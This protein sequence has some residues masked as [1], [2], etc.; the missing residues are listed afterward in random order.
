MANACPPALV[1][2]GDT[3]R[4]LGRG[5]HGGCVVWT[6][7]PVSSARSAR[8]DARGVSRPR[9][10]PAAASE[11]PLS[12]SEA[13]A[14]LFAQLYASSLKNESVSA[15][16]A[17]ERGSLL[18]FAYGHPWRWGEQR[19]EWAEQLKQRLGTPAEVLDGAHV[20]SLLARHPSAQGS[21]TGGRVLDAW[22]TG[23]GGG[24]SWLQTSDIPSPARRLYGA[25]GFAP[26]GHGPDAPDGTPG[27]V[28]YRNGDSR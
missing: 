22:L 4:I 25:R 7:D 26:I 27:L 9:A 3:S 6:R 13:V 19:D 24:P 18:G 21:G 2:L 17:Y 8:S 23:I 14:D 11:P 20:L 1:E 12:E 16:V 28:M 15:A 5:R 10:I